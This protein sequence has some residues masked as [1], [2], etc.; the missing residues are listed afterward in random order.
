M[1]PYVSVVAHTFLFIYY[2]FEF[3][4]DPPQLPSERGP[5]FSRAGEGGVG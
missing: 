5:L 4:T 3:P 1:I 2:D